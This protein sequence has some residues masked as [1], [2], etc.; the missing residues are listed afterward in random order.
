MDAVN[1]STFWINR[2]TKSLENF[3]EDRIM[4]ELKKPFSEFN[5]FNV[6][7]ILDKEVYEL[8]FV[9]K[10]VGLHNFLSI[11]RWNSHLWVVNYNKIKKVLSTKIKNGILS[12]QVIKKLLPYMFGIPNE[13]L[14]CITQSTSSYFMFKK[15]LKIWE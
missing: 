15:T 6:K 14:F 1:Y 4:L 7:Y 8:P 9:E 3:V 10:N 12:F 11:L 13:S 2:K 5:K